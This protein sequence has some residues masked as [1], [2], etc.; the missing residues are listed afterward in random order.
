MTDNATE[1]GGVT[2]NATEASDVTDNATEASDVTANGTEAGDVTANATEAGDVTANG[3]KAS[4]VTGAH[5]NGLKTRSP[6]SVRII[7]GHMNHCSLKK[8]LPP[9]TGNM[10]RHSAT[11][12]AS[13]TL[14]SFYSSVKVAYTSM[15]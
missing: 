12:N 5:V 11:R 10:I 8:G 4:G 15:A 2:A 9:N 7:T 14:D 13:R 1:A 6:D 3:T